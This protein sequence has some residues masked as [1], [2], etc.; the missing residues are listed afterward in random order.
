MLETLS[1]ALSPFALRDTI[2]GQIIVER[3]PIGGIA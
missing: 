1:S 2:Q 3:L